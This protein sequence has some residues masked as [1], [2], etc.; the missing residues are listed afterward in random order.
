VNAMFDRLYPHITRWAEAH[1]WIELRY[2]GYSRYFVRVL[3][4]GG[5]IG[6]G[7]ERYP[8]L[9]GAPHALERTLAEWL[10]PQ[11]VA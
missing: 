2:D 6:E 3:D 10:Q 11:G 1:G 4:L 9:D 5:M 7:L 8:T